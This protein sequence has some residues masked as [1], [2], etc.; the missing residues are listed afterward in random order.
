MPIPESMSAITYHRYGPEDV[1]T[2]WTVE[3]PSPTENECLIRV[4][5]S[6]VSRLDVLYRSGKL[7]LHGR[8]FPKGTG[9]DFLGEVVESRIPD[10]VPV[11]RWVWGVLGIEP[12]RSRGTAAEYLAVTRRQVGLFPAGYVPSLEVGALTLGALTALAALRQGLGVL[13]GQRILVAGGSGAVGSAALQICRVLDA[14]V[15]ALTSAANSDLC[16]ELGARNTFD[17]RD[18][19]SATAN[20]DA[21]VVAAGDPLVY[22][23]YVRPGGAAVCVAGDDW[24][25]A[26]WDD[27]PALLGSSHDRT[28]WLGSRRG[29]QRPAVALRKLAAGPDPIALDWLAAQVVEGTLRPVVA[30]RYGVADIVE[31]H[32][33]TAT[34]HSRGGR[35]V[36]HDW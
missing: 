12:F 24:L 1:L 22:R 28:A 27:R 2:R 11:G 19:P 34:G 6:G 3:T 20:Y 17:Y 10:Q 21:A 25:R 13:P 26:R 33:D 8:G 30:R 35:L 32:R 16:Q 36:V 14:E 7:R 29:G 18:L 4:A 31:A 5:A 23:R 15:D 9:F